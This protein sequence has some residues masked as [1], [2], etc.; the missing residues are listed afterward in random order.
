MKLQPGDLVEVITPPFKVIWPADSGIRP[1]IRGVVLSYPESYPE[2]CSFCLYVAVRLA[3]GT[4]GILI[5][6]L[7]KIDGPPPPEDDEYTERDAELI[8]EGSRAWKEMGG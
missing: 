1:G 3:V 6:A 5:A 7:K 4:K 2:H 8:F